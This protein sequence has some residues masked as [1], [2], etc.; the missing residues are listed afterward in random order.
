MAAEALAEL[1][2]AA[3]VGRADERWLRGWLEAQLE[4]SRESLR[5]TGHGPCDA[6]DGS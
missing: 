5:G 3:M 1:R 6:R 4:R 2:R